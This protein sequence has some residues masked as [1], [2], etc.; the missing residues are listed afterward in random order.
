MAERSAHEAVTTYFTEAAQLIGLDDE[1]AEVLRSSFREI[2]AQVP[3]RLD[4]G[5]LLVTRGYRVQHNDS[6][7]PCKGGIRFHP[8]VDIDEVRALAALMSWKTALVDVPFGGA[9]GGVQIDPTGLSAVELE[10]LTRRFTDVIS[11]LLGVYRDIPAPDVNTNAQVMAWMM[12]EW[13][14]LNGYE[15]AI[16]TGKPVALGGAPGREAATGR[17]CVFVLDAYAEEHRFPLE[18]AR[19][20]VQGFG[21]VGSW[22]ARELD[23]RGA[24]IVGLSDVSGAIHDPYGLDVDKVLA[25]VAEGAALADVD[26]PDHLGNEELLALDCDVLVPAALGRVLTEDNADRVR[27][28][29][30]VEAANYPVTPE[31][32]QVLWANGVDIIPDILANAGGVVGSYFEWS[33]NIQQF[34]WSEHEFNERLHQRMRRAYEDTRLACEE[35]RTSIRHAAYSIGIDR[36]ATATRLRGYI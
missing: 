36:V 2:E 18:G 25:L 32:D 19:V 30:L 16:V 5:R 3:L 7:G 35:L 31:A 33:M 23:Q 20:V 9:K 1:L 24:L 26:G 29:V 34:R 4:D 10:R 17:G 27:A 12:D 8:S 14:D 21:N 22:V 13:G 15:P 6:R 28:R 11:D